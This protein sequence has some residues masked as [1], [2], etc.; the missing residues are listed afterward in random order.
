M[1]EIF[2]FPSDLSYPSASL[3]T[4][5]SLKFSKASYLYDNCM[6]ILD[7]RFSSI[8]ET[9]SDEMIFEQILP[10]N[11]QRLFVLGNFSYGFGNYIFI[12]IAIGWNKLS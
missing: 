3:R 2:N 4:I 1:F 5:A 12:F 10:L 7:S 8:P 6:V 11:Q 9:V